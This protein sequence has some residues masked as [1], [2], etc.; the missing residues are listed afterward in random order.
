ML[1]LVFDTLGSHSL[2]DLSTVRFACNVQINVAISPIHAQISQCKVVVLLVKAVHE[3]FRVV[4]PVLDGACTLPDHNIFLLEVSPSP[5]LD[6]LA[7]TEDIHD[8]L[9]VTSVVNFWVDVSLGVLLLLLDALLLG[10]SLRRHE[11]RD[12]LR[13]EISIRLLL[14]L[15]GAN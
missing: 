4:L 15:V 5:Q 14:L 2:L 11:R 1:S 10:F 8:P 9:N 7:R 3:V 13:F 6:L 12:V